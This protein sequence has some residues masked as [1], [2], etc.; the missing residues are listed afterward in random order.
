MGGTD[1][2]NNLI[3]V[4][5][6]Q[7]IMW[8]FANWKLWGNYQDSV[9]YKLL[10][11]TDASKEA[12]LLRLQKSKEAIRNM[13]PEQRKNLAK[14]S[15]EIK[16]KPENR[17]KLSKLMKKQR[18][19]GIALT[20]EGRQRVLEGARKAN[21][22]RARGVMNTET[23]IIY[24]SIREAARQTNTSRNTIKNCIRQGLDKWV[25]V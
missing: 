22:A 23:G 18:L 9:A 25:E 15:A 19:N 5:I 17:E 2:P 4:S 10:A 20:E 6:T 24:P 11:N 16:R 3:E 12:E 21:E 1:D 14:K 7:H 13:T 8:H